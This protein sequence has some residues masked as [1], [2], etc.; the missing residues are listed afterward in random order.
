[1]QHPGFVAL[2]SPLIAYKEATDENMQITETD[3]KPLLRTS[4]VVRLRPTNLLVD[5]TEPPADFQA[6]ATHFTKN[7][8]IPRYGFFPPLQI[9][10]RKGMIP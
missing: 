2:D 4:S 1:M 7:P 6:T 3:S 5:N 10:P 9:T 8:D